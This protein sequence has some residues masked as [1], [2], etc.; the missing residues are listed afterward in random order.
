MDK[1]SESELHVRNCLLALKYWSKSTLCDIY[2]R[3][4][5]E[6]H[7]KTKLFSRSHTSSTLNY[8]AYGFILLVLSLSALGTLYN[9][10]IKTMWWW[11][12]KQKRIKLALTKMPFRRISYRFG[13]FLWIADFWWFT[14]IASHSTGFCKLAIRRWWV[15]QFI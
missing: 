5:I 14:K 11:T 7:I 12:S 4:D 6:L 15:R 9:I 2:I 1:I 8:I 13:I 10:K 3:V